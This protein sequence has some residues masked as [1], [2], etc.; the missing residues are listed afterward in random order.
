M[1]KYFIFCFVLFFAF[2]QLQAQ[3]PGDF[4]GRALAIGHLYGKVKDSKNKLAVGYATVTLL[5]LNKDS[6]ITGALVESNGDFSLEKIPFGKFRIRVQYIGYKT[7]IQ[8]VAITQANFEQ[9]LGDIKIESNAKNL[10]AVTVIGE[11]STVEMN[12]DRKVY[13]VEKDISSKGGN[14]LDVMKNVPGV[15]IDATGNVSLRNSTPVIFVDGKPTTLTLDQIPADQI[16][17]VEVIT[18]PSAKYDASATG[19][20]LNV[21][22]KHNSRPGYNGMVSAGVGNN[23]RYN[24]STLLNIK[25]KKVNFFISYNL[26]T[27]GS[28]NDGFTYKDNLNNN[29]YTGSYNQNNV[30]DQFNMMNFGRIG[31]DY[32]LTNRNT[33]TISQN[34]MIGQFNILDNQNYSYT[35]SLR[36]QILGGKRVNDQ[37]TYMHN[38]TSQVSF[39]H[40]FPTPGKELTSDITYNY[41]E[42]NNN[43]LYTTTPDTGSFPRQRTGGYAFS[44]Q[45][46]YQLDYAV[47]FKDSSKLEMGVKSNYSNYIANQDVSNEMQPNSDLYVKDSVLSSNYQIYTITNAAYINYGGK[48]SWFRY[49]TGLRLEQTSFFAKLRDK[50][51]SFYYAYP[52]GMKNL[53]KIF[54]PSI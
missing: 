38:Y 52:D 40:A 8:D 37:H 42:N 30:A 1:K 31:F 32:Y 22:M 45:I 13:N 29:R 21:V 39:R 50:D 4:A 2:Y 20:I 26:N 43:A 19:G 48:S 5:A 9:D 28:V 17:R 41:F 6:L 34:V 47:P 53:G 24:L 44:H 25:E 33:I 49:Q 12:I 54:F 14:G 35:D 7:Y 11:K 10:E 51:S 3:R 36:N 46:T 23:N 18:N 16:D 27:R 15:S